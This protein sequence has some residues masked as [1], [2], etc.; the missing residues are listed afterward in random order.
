MVKYTARV[1]YVGRAGNKK[2]PRAARRIT[3]PWARRARE[4]RPGGRALASLGSALERAGAARRA[5]SVEKPDSEAGPS[6]RGT[7]QPAR[8]P[9]RS[10]GCFSPSE[11]EARPGRFSVAGREA[12]AAMAPMAAALRSR[13][14]ALR[15]SSLLNAIDA[16]CPLALGG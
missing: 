13:Q 7:A 15:C 1:P 16:I 11:K 3:R 9:L 8:R 5:P 12:T 14:S 2:H 6:P 10:A 4:S